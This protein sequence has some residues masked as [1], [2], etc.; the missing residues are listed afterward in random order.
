MKK[1]FNHD[2]KVH[3]GYFVIPSLLVF[4]IMFLVLFLVEKEVRIS[5]IEELKPSEQRV[6]KMETDFIGREFSLVLSDLHYL[7]YAFHDEL[8][9]SDNYAALAVNWTEFATQKR[10]YDQIR[11]IDASGDE[12]IRI[13]HGGVVAYTVYEDDLQNKKD[14][15][16]FTEAIKLKAGSVYV[17]SFALNTEE[18]KIE[19]PYKPIIRLSTPVYDDHGKVKGIIVLNYL[20]N[21][22]LSEFRN[23]ASNSQGEII[24]LNAMGYRLSSSNLNDDWNFMFD[25]IKENTFEVEYPDEWLSII[26]GDAQFTTDKAIITASAVNLSEKYNAH[27]IIN[28]NQI[29]VLGDSEWYVVSVFKRTQNNSIY[30]IY[31]DWR[32]LVD[33]IMK[34][35]ITIALILII[36]GIVGYLGFT[37]RKTYSKIKYFSEYDPL[38]RTLN[39]RAGISRLNGLL[40]TSERRSFIGSLC[41]IDIDGLKDINDTLGHKM[42]DELIR[43]VSDVIKETIRAQDFLIRLG[44]DEFLIVFSGIGTDMAETIWERIVQSYNLINQKENRPYNISV[45]HGIV[46]FDNKQKTRVDELINAADEKMYQEKQIIKVGL[47]VIK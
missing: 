30:F 38:T 14:E 28:L 33:I 5:K 35:Y 25:S 2:N 43:T 34:N 4:M 45:S 13:N 39:R 11:F 27:K 32:L 22:M 46:N 1:K 15:D 3:I 44:G 23:M 10:V 26:K 6:V 40:P 31:D 7:H 16:Y 37:N 36:S 17:S 9:D 42:G 8:L 12:K 21:Y 24:L 20:A 18:G 47:R 41:F 29:I 19:F